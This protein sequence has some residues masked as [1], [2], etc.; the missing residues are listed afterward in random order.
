MEKL[1]NIANVTVSRTDLDIVGACVWSISFLKDSFGYHQGDLPLLGVISHLNG[2]SDSTPTI[3]V[4]EVK[5]GTYQEVQTI[6]VIAGSGY[7]D[8][9]SSFKLKF[10]G[11]STNPILALPIEGTSCLGSTTAKQIITT[12]TEDTSGRGGDSSVSPLTFFVLSYKSYSTSLIQA[13]G[14]S[15]EDTAT[16]IS[17]ELA[18]IPP[19]KEVTVLGLAS[20]QNDGGCN[21]TITLLGVQGNPELFEGL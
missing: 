8:S 4:S 21:W 10:G 5:K 14:G 7:V 16:K 6:K 9:A 20:G 13:N 15:C 1:P 2:G 17:Y 11:E 12:S 18:S 19:L 3:T